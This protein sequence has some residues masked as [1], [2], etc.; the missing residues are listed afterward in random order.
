MG[1][2][3]VLIVEDDPQASYMLE[4]A[5]NQ[6]PAFSVI[7]AAESIE[8]AKLM[9]APMPDLILLDI[10]L[11]DGNGMDL[12]PLLR[13]LCVSSSVIMTTAE[14]DAHVVAQAIQ[15]GVMDYLV[16]PLRFSRV[17]Q[18]LD[19]V[20]AF[21]QRL[22]KQG[23]VDQMQI[24][25]LLRKVPNRTRQTPKG[26]DT[27]T[28]TAMIEHIKGLTAPFSAQEVGDALKV[29][30]ITARRYLEYLEEQGTVTMSLSY[31]TGGR[32]KQLYTFREEKR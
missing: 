32:P 22:T 3:T 29:S 5:V 2:Y 30:R 8:Q 19:D 31:N 21:H 20:A 9:L 17:T 6:H 25:A 28:L 15:H 1:I 23:E 16:K 18:A 27:I 14:R 10:S 11:P 26:I 7:G 13:S 12:L 24:D 4:Q